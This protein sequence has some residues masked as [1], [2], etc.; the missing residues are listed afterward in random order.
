MS[1]KKKLLLVFGIIMVV[2]GAAYTAFYYI[3]HRAITTEYELVP[4]KTA[5]DRD[6][7]PSANFPMLMSLKPQASPSV[8]L[9]PGGV[10]SLEEMHDRVTKDLALVA[11]FAGFNWSATRCSTYPEDFTTFVS[12]RR[13]NDIRWSKNPILIKHG[14]AYCTDGARTFLMRCGNL[15]RM[16]PAPDAQSEDIPEEILNEPPIIYNWG[17]QILTAENFPPAPGENTVGTTPS[18]PFIGLPGG[19]S[20]GSTTPV[21]TPEPS[22]LAM[23]CWIGG[24][25]TIGYTARRALARL[26]NQRKTQI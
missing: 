16:S 8:S 24:G 25:L 20:G 12:F 6:Y 23:L 2:A 10:A 13:G 15:I 7:S 17:S 14:T 9:V 3:V 18:A 19:P 5:P 26:H 11:L 22:P 21:K 1:D 4:M